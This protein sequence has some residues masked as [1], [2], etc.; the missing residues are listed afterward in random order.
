VKRRA[1]ARRDPSARERE[2]GAFATPRL[3]D[4][5][6]GAFTRALFRFHVEEL[7]GLGDRL[8]HAH[9]SGDPAALDH[10]RAQ[11]RLVLE[12]LRWEDGVLERACEVA[13]EPPEMPEDLFAPLLL[14]SEMAP[15]GAPARALLSGASEPV[16]TRLALFAGSLP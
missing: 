1:P 13:A 4:E 7:N 2:P 11:C 3:T 14:V 12:A 16:R 9:A 5:Q 6:R 15:E 8:V 10:A